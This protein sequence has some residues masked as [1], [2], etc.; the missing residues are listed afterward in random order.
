MLD[1]LND[2]LWSKV[3]IVVLIGLGLWF[4]IGSRCVQ[5]RHFGRMFRI[6]G[7]NQAST[8]A[9]VDRAPTTPTD[10]RKQTER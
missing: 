3:L 8:A 10:C 9:R 4:T 6:L 7:A 5:F 2:L 1:L